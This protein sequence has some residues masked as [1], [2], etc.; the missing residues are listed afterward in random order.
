MFRLIF[1]SSFLLVSSFLQ[2]QLLASRGL[3]LDF[4]KAQQVLYNAESSWTID[5]ELN[6]QDG[7]YRVGDLLSVSILSPKNC[8]LHIFNLGP[9]GKLNVIWPTDPNISNQILA[10]ERTNFPDPRNGRS[11]TISATEPVGAE[12]LVFVACTSQ[13]R[14]DSVAESR[15]E[16]DDT[17]FV[18]DASRL[19]NNVREYMKSS[20]VPSDGWTILGRVVTTKSS[21]ERL[22]PD[23]NEELSPKHDLLGNYLLAHRCLKTGDYVSALEHLNQAIDQFEIAKGFAEANLLRGLVYE[24]L[25]QPVKAREDF[26]RAKSILR[27]QSKLYDSIDTGDQMVAIRRA[28]TWAIED[29]GVKQECCDMMAEK[30][31]SRFIE[32]GTSITVVKNRGD[33]FIEYRGATNDSIEVTAL[34]NMGKLS[35][36][37]P[38]VDVSPDE[39]VTMLD[40]YTHSFANFRMTLEYSPETGG[41][42]VSATF[43]AFGDRHPVLAY[44]AIANWSV[45]FSNHRNLRSFIEYVSTLYPFF[46]GLVVDEEGS[47]GAAKKVTI[48]VSPPQPQVIAFGVKGKHLLLSRDAQRYF[49]YSAWNC[50]TYAAKRFAIIIQEQHNNVAGQMRQLRGLEVLF[51]ENPWLLRENST[52]FLSEGTQD[53]RTLSVEPLVDVAASPSDAFIDN[54]IQS[55]LIPGY[56]AYEWKH[57]EGVTIAGY[58]DSDLYRISATLFTQSFAD[59]KAARHLWWQAVIARNQTMASALVSRLGEFD[60]PILFMGGRH[61]EGLDLAEQS[62]NWGE[63]KG[64]LPQSDIDVLRR[65]EKRGVKDFLQDEGVGYCYLNCR[66]PLL[67]PYDYEA[68]RKQYFDL[69]DAQSNDLLDEYIERYTHDSCPP[70]RPDIDACA[71]FARKLQGLKRADAFWQVPGGGLVTHELLGG[72]HTIAKHIA[73]DDA[74]LKNRLQ[75]EPARSRVSS[76]YDYATAERSVSLAIEKNRDKVDAWL[77]SG[78]SNPRNFRASFGVSVGRSIKRGE[79]SSTHVNGVFV[80]LAPDSNMASGYRI[81]TAYPEP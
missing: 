72:P 54:C 30:R 73:K 37:K 18:S 10:N 2:S 33:G 58:E 42:P 64:V 40:R 50:S 76:F 9:D 11:I 35:D 56:V 41:L 57:K 43:T 32:A 39:S 44:S 21:T 25:D 3:H 13:L 27:S 63:L 79:Q 7:V 59:P 49:S 36:T 8:Y 80:R 4:E 68:R 19:V 75:T 65:F 28:Q 16:R 6:H 17:D 74:W 47:S 1:I 34:Q 14:L 69:F 71:K 5:V 38:P 52:C 70:T 29:L 81:V 53:G 77:K 31:E 78:S 55:L 61:M 46:E 26:Q 45:R 23:E 60:L 15:S 66:T 62:P 24:R 48:W 12:L 22:Q 20:D 51:S 67:D